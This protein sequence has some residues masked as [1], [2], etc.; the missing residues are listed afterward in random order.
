MVGFLHGVEVV[1]VGSGPRPTETV[2]S[3]IIGLIGTA[4]D[5]DVDKFPLDTPVLVT[6]R[7]GVSGIG[8]TGTLPKALAGIFDQFSPFIVV[9]RVSEA[10][11]PG[12]TLSNVIGGID[13]ATGARKGVQA[14]RDAQ[15]L[16]GV[17]PMILVAPGF[18]STRPSALTSITVSNQGTGYTSVPTVTFS[19]G[20]THA[21]K[22]LPTGIA[23]LGT[24]A[25]AGKVVSVTITDPGRFLDAA[26]TIA[27]TGGGGTS[28]AATVTVAA[29]ANPAAS[30]LRAVAGQLRAHVVV[31]G[32][33]TTDAAAITYRGD[34]S[35]R[36]VYVVDPHVKVWDAAA[37]S[38]D[39]GYVSE[40]P[41]ARIAGLI[42]K[43]DH[44]QGFWKSPSNEEIGGIGGLDRPIDFTLGDPNTRANLLNGNEVATIIRDGGFLLWGNRT[45]SNDPKWAFLCVSRTA[46]MIDISIQQGHRWACDQVVNKGYVKAVVSSV[47]AY[48]RQL[49]ARGAI[50]G[51]KCWFDPDFNTDAD[52]AAGKVT[53]SYDFTAP[54]P[55]EHVTFRSTIT[56]DYI[57]SI[58]A[59][60]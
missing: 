55:A 11:S 41:A 20:G 9:V 48:L 27:L 40:D 58:F 30:A 42:A 50:L 34:F 53:F 8:A 59:A 39:G 4:A 10:N 46:D 29:A 52:I 45:T 1:T 49:Q 35:D 19:G 12:A 3:S 31:A 2:R 24:D 38:G 28:A 15:S 23:V 57:A 33:N 26:P 37:N 36:R 51:G 21:D 56:D 47:N 18:T 16:C 14:F 5:A 32:P 43:V 60:A 17:T 25:N 7:G 54:Y 6:T 44:E 13:G 22:V